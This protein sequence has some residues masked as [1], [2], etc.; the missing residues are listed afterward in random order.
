MFKNKKNWSTANFLGSKESVMI[1]KNQHPM[2][3][4]RLRAYHTRMSVLISWYWS[5]KSWCKAVYSLLLLKKRVENWNCSKAPS[6]AARH[7]PKK[8]TIVAFAFCA[9]I[10]LF[11]TMVF[12]S[13][14]FRPKIKRVDT[15]V[16]PE[17]QFHSFSCNETWETTFSFA[18]RI[19]AI[20]F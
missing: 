1:I 19:M 15:S 14:I 9:F 12:T 4:S 2:M 7:S 18:V 11:F 5:C 17:I 20:Q 13:V 6:Y 3:Q 10:W 16:L 8:E